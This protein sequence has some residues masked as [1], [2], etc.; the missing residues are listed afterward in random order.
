MG[1]AEDW[2]D[3]MF[4]LDCLSKGSAKRK[5]RKS[6]KYGWGGL[7][8]YCRSNRATTLDHIKPKSKGGSSL[9][10]NLIPCCQECNHSKGSEPWLVWFK[11]QKFYNETA[12]ELIE[13][14]ISN[15]RFIEEELDECAVNNRA[16]F[17]SYESEI[18]SYENEPTSVREDSFTAA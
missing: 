12:K 15:K 4:S 7:C 2:A 14:W 1:I 8:A 10:S 18:R 11:R 3:L 16:T 13:E 17:C 6:I 9:R 5:F